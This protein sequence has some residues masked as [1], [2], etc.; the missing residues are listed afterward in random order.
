MSTTLQAAPMAAPTHIIRKAAIFVAGLTIASAGM[1]AGAH[2]LTAHA[3]APT[4]TVSYATQDAITRTLHGANHTP[5]TAGDFIDA[6]SIQTADVVS[7][8]KVAN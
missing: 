5:A 4:T 7:V 1:Y 6:A 3:N 8:V 2:A